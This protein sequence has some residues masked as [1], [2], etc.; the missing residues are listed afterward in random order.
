MGNEEIQKSY[1]VDINNFKEF[2][3]DVISKFGNY[4]NGNFAFKEVLK[5]K[6]GDIWLTYFHQGIQLE[7]N[8]CRHIC[9]ISDKKIELTSIANPNQKILLEDNFDGL[10]YY[11]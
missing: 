6:L 2:E 8:V 1:Y 7:G 11:A 4:A 5:A 10:I 3:K 9:N